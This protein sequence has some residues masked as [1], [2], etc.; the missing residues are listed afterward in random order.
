MLNFC[1]LVFF[2]G[3]NPRMSFLYV[4][5]T[6]HEFF[7]NTYIYVLKIFLY[8]Y[9]LSI[10]IYVERNPEVT[11]LYTHAQKKELLIWPG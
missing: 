1:S 4:Y 8:M 7:F 5:S 3:I 9:S 6:S 10:Y 11:K 2:K